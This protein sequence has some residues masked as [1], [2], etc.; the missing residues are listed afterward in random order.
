MVKHGKD[1]KRRSG[2]VGKTK[3]KNRTY[4]RWNPNPR[5]TDPTIKA[6]WDPSKSPAV[7]LANLGL[8][9]NLNEDIHRTFDA[10][11]P[12]VSD[13]PNVVELFNIPDSDELRLQKAAKRIPLKVED[14]KYIVKCLKRHGQDFGKIFR[15][16]KVNYMQ[17]TETQLTKM[18]ARFLLLT[19]EQ[20][21]VEVPECVLTLMHGEE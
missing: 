20:R 19:P 21:A 2:R 13:T 14:Q 18:G 5:F 8:K 10:P 11:V 17:Y 6:H 9:S 15:D 4:H 16:T 3:L 12:T 7:N 1:K